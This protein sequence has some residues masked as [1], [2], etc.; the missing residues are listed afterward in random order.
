MRR[1]QR[2]FLSVKFIS[3]DHPRP[4]SLNINEKLPVHLKTLHILHCYIL[5]DTL[6]VEFVARVEMM[7]FLEYYSILLHILPNKHCLRFGSNRLDSRHSTLLDFEILG[8]L[9]TESASSKLDQHLLEE[10]DCSISTGPHSTRRSFQ[11]EHGF[12]PNLPKHPRLDEQTPWYPN[13]RVPSRAIPSG[14]YRPLRVPSQSWRCRRRA[15]AGQ[16]VVDGRR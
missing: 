10:R 2:T 16:R 14:H 1:Y 12:H 3:C 11:P 13:L 9:T 5:P 4:W 7:D 6:V 8:S 15:R